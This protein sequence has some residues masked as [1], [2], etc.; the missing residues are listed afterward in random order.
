MLKVPG[1]KTAFRYSPEFG[2]EATWDNGQT[3]HFT[4]RTE[5]ELREMYPPMVG[6]LIE[7]PSDSED[8]ER[9]IFGETLDEPIMDEFWEMIS[10]T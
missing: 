2:M 7:T 8:E 9:E 5:S 6:Q 1:T 10:D 4:F 3:W